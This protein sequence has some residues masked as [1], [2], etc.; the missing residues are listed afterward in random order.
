[1][2]NMAQN[3]R[4]MTAALRVGGLGLVIVALAGAWYFAWAWGARELARRADITLADLSES[5]IEIACTNRQVA[6]FPFRIGILCDETS[7]YS[8]IQGD[9]AGA[10]AWRSAAQFYDPGRIIAELDGPARIEGSGQIPLLA[11]W[12][13]LRASARLGQEGVTAFSV[14]ATEFGLVDGLTSEPA[15]FATAE[16]ARL[17][18]R[19][20]PDKDGAIDL[21]FSAEKLRPAASQ[22][23]PF[24][25]ETNIRVEALSGEV[26]PGFDLTEFVR[27]NGLSGN[28]ADFSLAPESGG[29]LAA[30]GSFSISTD[31]L[32]S[33][34]I[35]FDVEDI[36]ALADFAAQVLPQHRDLLST[37]GGTLKMLSGS[38]GNVSGL[39]LT[40]EG[41]IARLGPFELGRIP[42][43]F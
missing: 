18:G 25:L 42:P 6:G 24:D 13:S 26:G 22:I 29:R 21:A 8:T 27:S 9:R 36:A 38:G 2:N 43:L 14:E 12:E 30:F 35:L 37:I 33:A 15:P 17:H 28:I 3:R 11:N 4:G 5:G 16:L 7:V 32:V 31:G 20:A 10:G 39:Q 23:A 19:L 40:V 41:G 34:N 1:M